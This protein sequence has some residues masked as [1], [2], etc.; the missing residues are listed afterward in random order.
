[1][2][3]EK[4][5]EKVRREQLQKETEKRKRQRIEAEM[6]EIEEEDHTDLQKIMQSIDKKDVPQDMLLF[7]D[8]QL[9]IFKTKS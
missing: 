1:M 2:S 4:V 8:Q 9:D 5:V 7:W 6:V 3:R